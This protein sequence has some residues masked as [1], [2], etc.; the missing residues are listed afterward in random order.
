MAFSLPPPSPAV[1][2]QG[3]PW[4]LPGEALARVIDVIGDYTVAV[5]T[6]LGRLTAGLLKA[7]FETA[8]WENT[9]RTYSLDPN[10]IAPNYWKH[11]KRSNESSYVWKTGD[12]RLFIGNMSSVT[13]TSVYLTFFRVKIER[14][15][16][17]EIVANA[18]PP[19]PKRSVW[20]KR[21]KEPPPPP[22]PEPESP[23]KG[24]PVAE[25]HLKAWYDLYQRAYSGAADTEA[26]AVASARGMFPGKSVSRDRVRALRGSQKR[27][28]KPT[29]PAE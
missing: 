2:L 9:S 25:E 15:G 1:N 4:L 12:L 17:D 3:A 23:Q 6:I 8:K 28:R 14:Q 22:A 24:P 26:T 27:G 21:P 10:F 29:E 5:D 18:A 19:R 7:T 13:E 20:I 16:I 11:Y